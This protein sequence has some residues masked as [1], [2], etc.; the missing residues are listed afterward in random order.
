MTGES[1]ADDARSFDDMVKDMKDSTE[2]LIDDVFDPVNG[3][4]VV[5]VAGFVITAKQAQQ[6]A[7]HLVK[8]LREMQSGK[9]S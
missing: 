2:K 7:P 6:I 1:D 4:E 9:E 8:A 3:P 5:D